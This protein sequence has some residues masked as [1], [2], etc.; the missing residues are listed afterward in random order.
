MTLRYLTAGESHGPGAGGHR[1][2]IPGRPASST[3]R[4]WTATCA[5]AR[6]ATG[7]AD[8]RRSRPTRPSSWPGLRG[9]VTTGAP[10]ALVIWNKD[11]ENWKELVSPYARGGRKF[12]QVR[13]GPRRPGRRAQVRPRRRP[14]RAGAGQ[15]PLHRDD[16]GAGRAW[17]ARCSAASGSRSPPG[18]WPSAR[19]RRRSTS[20][21]RPSSSAAIEA[22][23]LHVERRGAGRGVARPHRRREGRGVAPS[24]APSR[25]TPP[26]S[27]SAW[28]A[29]STRTGGSTP[30]W[31]RPCA[32]S[33]PSAG[34][35]WATGSRWAA[36]ATSSTTPS[37]TM[38]SAASGERPTAPAVSR[39]G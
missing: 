5:A 35:R 2:G 26:A 23:D 13:P 34:S 10:I 12:T 24:A 27:P 39:A 32:G 11:H 7:G 36:R 38:R 22:S 4:R 1:R 16:R 6:R 17:R 31:P 15:R 37:T 9:G 29:T 3:S 33:R 25:S 18:W 14:R 21:P 20:R 8:A 19:A 28:A 30:G